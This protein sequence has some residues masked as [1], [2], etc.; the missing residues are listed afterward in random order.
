MA[1][2]E[3]ACGYDIVLTSSNY[4]S[5]VTVVSG[6]KIVFSA[7]TSDVLYIGTKNIAVVSTVVNY[8]YSP[9]TLIA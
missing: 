2:Q 3:P 4:P 1:I 6:S 8:P 9:P 5:Y 7:Y